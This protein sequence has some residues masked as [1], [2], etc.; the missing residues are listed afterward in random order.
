VGHER[1]VKGKNW[2]RIP[3]IW[4]TCWHSLAEAVNQ[5]LEKGSQGWL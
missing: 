4:V 2:E 5:Y 3:W 1:D